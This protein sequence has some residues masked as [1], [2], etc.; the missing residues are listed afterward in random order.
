MVNEHPARMRGRETDGIGLAS[1]VVL[2]LAALMVLVFLMPSGANIGSSRSPPNGPTTSGPGA[3][4]PPSLTV[5]PVVPITP[6][7]PPGSSARP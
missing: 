2:A 3:T 4:R 7:D 6:V 1:I 5:P